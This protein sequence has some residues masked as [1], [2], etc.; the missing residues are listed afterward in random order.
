MKRR[1]FEA[2]NT[3]ATVTSSDDNRWGSPCRVGIVRNQAQYHRHYVAACLEMGVPFEVL[4]LARVDWIDHVSASGCELILVWPDAVLTNW[5]AM[6][7]DRVEILHRCLGLTVVPSRDEIWLYED[8]RRMVEWMRANEVP[9]ARTWIFF[10]RHE[11]DA[12]VESCELPVVFKANFG[13]SASG[14]RIVRDRASLRS[15]VRTLFGKG[16]V[17]DG[18]DW[19]DRQWGTMLLQEY[20]PDVREWRMVRIGDSYFGHRKGRVGDFHSGSGDVVWDVPEPRHLDLLHDVTEKGGFRSMDVDLFEAADGRLLVNEL[21]AV[22][23]AAFSVDQLRVNDRA[24]RFVRAPGAGDWRFEEGDYAR[25]ACAN[26]RVR[27]ALTRWRAD[28]AQR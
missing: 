27:D 20:L 22:F 21:Q 23:G 13:A 14:V 12:F 4:D 6:I 18:A 17:P 2:G 9:H 16:F 3:L 28:K 1:F 5:A 15:L 7:K 11:I 25:N 24:G 8:K 26:E 10:H 19:R